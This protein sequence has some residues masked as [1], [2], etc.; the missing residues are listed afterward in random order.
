MND[1]NQL[2][3]S[4]NEKKSASKFSSGLLNTWTNL[5]KLSHFNHD[6]FL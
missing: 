5:S 2:S 4:S 3:C 6:G 1:M